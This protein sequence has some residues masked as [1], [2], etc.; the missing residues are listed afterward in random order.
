M[1]ELGIRRGH[2]VICFGQLYGMCDQISFSLGQSGYSVYKYVPYGPVEEVIPYLSRR[3]I[4]NHGIIKNAKKERRLM[5][6][7]VLRRVMT[8]DVFH[9]PVGNYTPI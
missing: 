7:E 2:K 4:E 1:K 5:S 6:K 8:G 3:A 9:K